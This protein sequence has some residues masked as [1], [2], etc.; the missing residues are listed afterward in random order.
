MLITKEVEVVLSGNNIKHYEEKGYKIP[1]R[2][3][4]QGRL[5]LPVGSKI[6]VD[7][8]DIPSG[9][10]VEIQ[11]MCDYCAEEGHG[12]PIS[13]GWSAYNN[14]K[15]DVINKDACSKHSTQKAIDL[16]TRVVK[17]M[18]FMPKDEI[19][20][21]YLA[22]ASKI[23]CV[24]KHRH[25]KEEI[26]INS[27]FPSFRTIQNGFD[28]L[29]KLKQYC[30]LETQWFKYTKEEL[31]NLLKVY[32]GKNGFPKNRRN[33]FTSKNGLPSYKTYIFQFGDDLVNLIELCGYSLT[34]DEKYHLM[35]KSGIVVTT[36]KQEAIE[37]I[38]DMQK[39]LKRPLMYDDFRNPNKNTVSITT[40]I[41]FWGSMNKMKEELG[42]EIIQENML[43]KQL[44]LEDAKEHINKLCEFIFN[45]ENRKII[46]YR[47]INRCDYTQ[48]TGSYNKIF[49]K[50]LGM[51]LR[52][53][54]QSIGYDL[55]QEGNG[56][57][58]IFEDG[59]K[60]RSQYELDFSIYLRDMLHLKYN[61]NYFRDIRYKTFMVDYKGLMDCDYIIDFK[62]R[63]IYIEIAGMLR[64]RQKYYYEDKPLTSKSKEKYRQKLMLKEDMLKDSGV[65]YYILFPCDLND[66]TYKKIFN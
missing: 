42:L 8:N 2:I 58:H 23:R 48:N 26:K 46:T 52:E 53:Y 28:T 49:L 41:K 25:I 33:L 10:K 13:L 21:Q 34:E 55:A 24:P 59:E 30:K 7:V 45:K 64:D 19:V 14:H 43:D 6:I 12:V 9:S 57:N 15:N 56:L 66:D 32:I 38:Y 40:I 62:G 37:I 29:S 61:V 35:N 50:E 39:E 65:E 3:D 63:K 60:T 51:K 31:L 36:T 17:A 16:G 4:K 11:Y 22:L 1:R 54:I 27:N 18:S 20:K 5:S 47:D 44:T